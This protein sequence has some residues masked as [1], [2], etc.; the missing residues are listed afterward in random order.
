MG[1][2]GLLH[3]LACGLV[4]RSRLE[5]VVKDHRLHRPAGIAEG[6]QQ[7]PDAAPAE[8]QVKT[9]GPAHTHEL[10][11]VQEAAV[12]LVEPAPSLEE[13]G[14]TPADAAGDLTLHQIQLLCSS[15]GWSLQQG[16]DGG[17]SVGC[18][19]AEVDTA[20][21]GNGDGGKGAIRHEGG[22]ELRGGVL[23]ALRV[24]RHASA[25]ALDVVLGH[26]DLGGTPNRFHNGVLL[27]GQVCAPRS[28][29]LERLEVADLVRGEA[30]E[31]FDIFCCGLRAFC[32]RGVRR[33]ERRG[34]E[35]I[36][37]LLEVQA[38]AAILVNPR[39]DQERLIAAHRPVVLLH[40]SQEVLQRDLS[41]MV[42]IKELE[43]LVP[44]QQARRRASQGVTLACCR[45]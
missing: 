1:H 44:A 7:R 26:L 28:E 5:E 35:D 16:V 29:G 36:D 6:T 23:P 43:K 14:P 15:G 3:R 8:A 27:S 41:V 18:G 13:V 45:Q 10:L 25:H 2:R 34:L 32:G 9:L 12:V 24:R 42:A 37:K 21:S 40:A 20:I 31:T 39:E 4:L 38:A 17:R 22:N 11:L 19:V 30:H 33:R